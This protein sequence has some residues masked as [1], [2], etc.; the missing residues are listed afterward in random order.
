M[1][2]IKHN[3]FTNIISKFI[4]EMII[5]EEGKWKIKILYI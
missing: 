1:K 3:K 2:L 5:T 4:Y